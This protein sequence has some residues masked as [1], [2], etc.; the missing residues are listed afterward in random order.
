MNDTTAAPVNPTPAQIVELAN[1]WHDGASFEDIVSAM[2]L[3]RDTVYRW[4]RTAAVKLAV[5]GLEC[6]ADECVA[7]K[8][9]ARARFGLDAG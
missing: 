3:D 5:L 6:S 9:A 2:G 1:R 7:R 4:K 8:A